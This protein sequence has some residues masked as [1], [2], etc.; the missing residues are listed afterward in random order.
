MYLLDT[1]HCSKIIRG[2]P[3][4]LNRLKESSLSSFSI[5]AIVFGELVFMAFNSE[6]HEANLEK[7]ISLCARLRCFPLDNG[8]AEIY[9]RLKAMLIEKIGPREILKRRSFK[10][11]KLG[12]HDNDLWITSV[13]I[14]HDLIILTTDSDFAR[15]AE[16]APVKS[17]SWI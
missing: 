7:V 9:G 15:I 16:H 10:L 13:A 11:Q 4:L 1:N 17:E 5:C 8:T 12:I 14:Q 3:S 6:F 2:E